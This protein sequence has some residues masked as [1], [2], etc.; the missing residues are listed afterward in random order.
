MYRVLIDGFCV[1]E[2]ASRSD[3]ELCA[4]EYPDE[5]DATVVR[6]A[7]DLFRMW[8]RKEDRRNRRRNKVNR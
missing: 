4:A 3:A 6:T 8:D 2:F 1:N 5:D 7:T